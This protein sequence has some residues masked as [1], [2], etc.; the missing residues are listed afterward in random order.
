LKYLDCSHNLISELIFPSSSRIGTIVC[1]YNP[2]KINTKYLP[3]SVFTIECSSIK[4]LICYQSE[5][6]FYD[7]SSQCPTVFK[8]NTEQKRYLC[9]VCMSGFDIG[10]IRTNKYEIDDDVGSLHKLSCIYH[11]PELDIGF[12]EP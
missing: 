12:I 1:S 9:G 3:P 8:D 6:I 7:V 10:S 2:I 4:K 11:E 5:N